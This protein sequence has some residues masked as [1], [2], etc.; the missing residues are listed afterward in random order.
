MTENKDRKAI[1]TT[2]RKFRDNLPLRKRI[3]WSMQACDNLMDGRGFTHASSIFVFVSFGSEINT[4]PILERALQ[5]DIKV[6]V[7]VVKGK[8]M[9]GIRITLNHY[10]NRYKEP[11][12]KKNRYN[13]P[14]PTNYSSKITT[15]DDVDIVVVPGL[16][17]DM[18]GYRLGYG[19]G[20]YDRFLNGRKKS[21]AAGLCFHEQIISDL[22][23][24]P[25][26][27]K[28]DALYTEKGEFRFN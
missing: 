19:G 25:H 27:K 7:P 13:I 8:E 18:K 11:L 24:E 4:E 3:Q 28:I 14:E 1:R 22:P 2:M 17:F 26:D 5:N 21:F 9:I 10:R 16:A 6:Y 15:A 23:I 20:F 12:W